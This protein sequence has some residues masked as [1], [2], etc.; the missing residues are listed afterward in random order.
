METYLVP[1]TDVLLGASLEHAL[2]LRDAV[3]AVDEAV[4]DVMLAAVSF[5]GRERRG[6]A[7]ASF[8]VGGS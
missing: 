6:S 1:L 3:L 2:V 4:E 5:M 7:T 8:G